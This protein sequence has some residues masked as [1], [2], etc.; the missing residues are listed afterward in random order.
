MLRKTHRDQGSPE[1]AGRLGVGRG[2]CQ[3]S[4]IQLGTLLLS[5]FSLHVAF[6]SEKVISQSIVESVVALWSLCW[7]WGFFCFVFCFLG[8][9]GWHMEVPSL[10]IESELQLLAY[11]TAIAMPGPSRLCDLHHSSLPH[12]VL[13]PRSE[14]RDRTLILTDLKCVTPDGGPPWSLCF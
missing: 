7:F 8:L 5:A 2:V 13:N 4:S 1:C 10:G 11:T 9:H 12:W 3:L 14:A 6:C